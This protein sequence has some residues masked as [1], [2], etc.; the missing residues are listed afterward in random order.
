MTK[1][2]AFVVVLAALLLAQAMPTSAGEK[3]WLRV[4]SPN[5]VVYTDA[6]E[7]RGR[8]IAER[9]ES[10]RAMLV[11]LFPKAVAA[12]Q[13]ERLTIVAFRDGGAFKPYK[14]LYNG[15]PANVA[16]V[17]FQGG[18]GRN[19]VA[20]D[21]SSRDSGYRVVFH[22]YMHKLLSG[23][24]TPPPAW[25]NEGLAEFY[26]SAEMDGLKARLGSAIEERMYTLLNERW[27]PLSRLL[28]IDHGSP[29]YNE[30][31]MQG[32]FYA[33]SWILVHYLML[34][35]NGKYQ[36]ALA[37][38]VSR[39]SL[40]EPADK[41]FAA[42]F[43]GMPMQELEKALQAYVRRPTYPVFDI[44]FSSA[45]PVSQATVE[46]A[47]P[48]EVE[49]QLGQVL[50][51][52]QRY[53]D[54]EPHYRKALELDQASSLP[55]EGLG[56]IAMQKRDLATARGHFSE[57]VK[58][59]SKSHW[60]L[61]FFA[62]A[63]MQLGDGSADPAV[64]QALEKTIA[65]N[66]AF[67]PPYGMLTYLFGQ[68]G[69]VKKAIEV[70][71]KGLVYAPQDAHLRLNLASSLMND[72][73]LD[74][75][76]TEL[77]KVLQI[78]DNDGVREMAQRSLDSLVRHE[79]SVRLGNEA[80]RSAGASA[81]EPTAAEPASAEP[82]TSLQPERPKLQRSRPEGGPQLRLPGQSSDKERARVEGV[83]ERLECT[84][85]K[86]VA[87][88]DVGGRKLVFSNPVMDDVGMV[89]TG[90][91]GSETIECGKVL[92]RPVVLSL[93]KDASNPGSFLLKLIE[94]LGAGT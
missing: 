40:G 9:L 51:F 64:R 50:A 16:G 49:Y 5:F 10:F 25:F 22:E 36:K 62:H 44:T 84:D 15:K 20:L 12:G 8:A 42:A 21:A 66:P 79:E 38:L 4:T 47:P 63:S 17:F 3:P 60:A 56:F 52:S 31:S 86:L 72:Q 55:H 67:A 83:L 11:S 41:A 88:V 59:D 81:G 57:A 28:T 30:K 58:R 70:A 27:L 1:R 46:P 7:K 6:S 34:G 45:L 69:D 43:G 71:R 19:M 92:N 24:D 37:Q 78:A 23:D 48:A 80:M 87:Y 32:N 82:A 75:A 91:A 39:Q 53:D 61:F 18:F 26:S 13:P 90:L 65:L 77:R 76:K 85:G 68:A 89:T 93:A 73:Q 94:F 33:Q 35:E 54:A 29:E 2:N 74:A 14:P